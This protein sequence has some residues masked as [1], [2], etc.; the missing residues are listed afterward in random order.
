MKRSGGLFSRIIE[1][2]N[3]LHA[4]NSAR[5]GK[6]HYNDVKAVNAQQD[7]MLA[8]IQK[9]LWAKTFTTSKY[10]AC[11]KF[12]GRKMRLIHKLPYYPDRIVQHALI[13]VCEPVWTKT[14]I[15]DTFQ[16]IPGRGTSDARKRV[17]KAIKNQPGKYA[18]KFDIKK[19]YP[20]VDHDILR[21]EIRRYIKCPDTLWLLDDIIRSGPGIPIGNYTSQHFGN[22]YL[23]RFDWWV[24]QQLG[25]K[26]YFRYCDD[27]VLIADSAEQCHAWREQCFEKL[28]AEFKLEIK[29]NWQVFS[30][31]ERGLDFVGYVFYPDRVRL[32]RTMA[33]K[34]RRKM[35][36]MRRHRKSMAKPQFLGGTMAYWGWV[37]HAN[38][39]ALWKSQ[40]C[41]AISNKMAAFGL[42]KNPLERIMR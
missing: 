6:A 4:H 21:H 2:E 28:R 13:S 42:K 14:Y 12:D 5:R 9:D 20:S 22:L 36:Y 30:L 17:W 31:D 10:I 38:A 27:I 33:N 24:K 8:A 26:H 3:I 19:Y 1:P 34:F 23:N 11:H 40:I 29:D 7:E 18:L 32:R 37:K 16:S 41:R 15:R 25:V 39:K 35:R